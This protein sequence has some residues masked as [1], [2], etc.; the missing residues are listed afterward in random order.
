MTIL[1]AL[2]TAVNGLSYFRFVG[3]M[4]PAPHSITT[5]P[6]CCIYPREE[7]LEPGAD[8]QI[9][10][11]IRITMLAV[12]ESGGDLMEA[13]DEAV[14]KLESIAESDPSLGGTVDDS[15]NV[16]VDIGYPETG[17]PKAYVEV[18]IQANYLRERLDAN[19]TKNTN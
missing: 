9:K 17:K 13:A 18:V 4:H 14:E 15:M 11:T 7:D 5:L 6:A 16:Q 3:R 1:K 10:K 19:S 12:V 2:E 8:D